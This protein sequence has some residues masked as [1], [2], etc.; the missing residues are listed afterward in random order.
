[1]NPENWL[2]PFEGFPKHLNISSGLKPLKQF[3]LDNNPIILS[4]H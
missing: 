1:M 3:E 2:N 4:L